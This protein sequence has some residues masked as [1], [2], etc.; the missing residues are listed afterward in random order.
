MRKKAAKERP[1]KRNGFTHTQK[2]NRER[3]LLKSEKS[4]G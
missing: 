3:R 2:K 1:I 4:R